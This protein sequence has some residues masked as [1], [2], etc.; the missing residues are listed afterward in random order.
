MGCSCFSFRFGFCYLSVCVENLRGR[1]SW[2]SHVRVYSSGIKESAHNH[3]SIVDPKRQG[4]T[5]A[6]DINYGVRATAPQQAV[7]VLQ[8]VFVEAIVLNRRG[9]D[10]TGHYVPGSV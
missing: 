5:G 2:G 9:I 1:A 4:G 8:H 6:R 7:E 3:T 10:K